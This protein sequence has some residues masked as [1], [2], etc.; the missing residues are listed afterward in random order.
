MLLVS[1][2]GRAGVNRLDVKE[3]ETDKRQKKRDIQD[4][5]QVVTVTHSFI[6]REG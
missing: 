2:Q 4:K 3:G 5:M 1:R 6:H